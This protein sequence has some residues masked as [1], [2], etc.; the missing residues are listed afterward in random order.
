MFGEP[1]RHHRTIINDRGIVLAAV[2]P[3]LWTEIQSA[4]RRFLIDT[5]FPWRQYL[6]DGNH[7]DCA[8][9]MGATI[10]NEMDRSTAVLFGRD[11]TRVV[12]EHFFVFTYC[13]DYPGLGSHSWTL[14]R[15]DEHHVSIHDQR[16][17]E[18]DPR[19]DL[20]ISRRILSVL[21]NQEV[22]EAGGRLL[23]EVR[24][25]LLNRLGHQPGNA[26]E[27]LLI[28]EIRRQKANC[29]KD[30][31]L[32]MHIA[33]RCYAALLIN[34]LR[35]RNNLLEKPVN[36]FEDSVLIGEALFLNAE[37]LSRDNGVKEMG[38][39]CQIAVRDEP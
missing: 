21:Q 6:T 7:S 12:A 17:L 4:R 28:Q 18:Q 9:I 38:R 29:F 5:H 30:M 22:K 3:D 2:G 37:V 24:R 27:Q 36:G 32:A 31:F 10:Q 34:C 14:D 13:P 19:G 1:L 8:F 39:Y 11:G 20:P 23:M 35:A 16:A 15:M 33:H 25:E 26:C